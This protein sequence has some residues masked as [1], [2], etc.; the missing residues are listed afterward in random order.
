MCAFF[1]HFWTKTSQKRLV[2]C[3]EWT[4]SNK[5]APQHRIRMMFHSISCKKA[6]YLSHFSIFFRASLTK[7]L[8]Y[9]FYN[10][11]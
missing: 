11:L 7:I 6:H 4:P 9:N 8:P 1:P 10:Q 2:Y 3:I 5:S